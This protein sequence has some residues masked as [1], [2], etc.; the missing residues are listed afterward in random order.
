MCPKRMDSLLLRRLGMLEL[1]LTLGYNRF[2]QGVPVGEALQLDTADS[3]KVALT[4]KENGKAK[5]P[6]QAFVIIR[7]EGTNLEAPFALTIK[8]SGKAAVEIVR[9]LNTPT[10]L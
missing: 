3:I 1:T 8:D 5:K 6:H 10:L 4:L 2:S 9:R 7:E